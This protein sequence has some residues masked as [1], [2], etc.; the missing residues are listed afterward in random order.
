[1]ADDICSVAICERPS[2]SRGWC[3][4]HYM[5]WYTTGDVRA[6]EPLQPYGQ[7]G[8]KIEGCED[9]TKG[10]R[11]WCGKH[12][13][14]WRKNGDPHDPGRT[15]RSLAERLWEKVDVGHP[16]GCW[17]WTG[18]SHPL[19]YGVIRRGGREEGTVGAHRAAYEL[20]VGGCPDGFELDHLCCNPP[21]V[22]PDHL[23][24]VTHA[25][26]A[27]RGATGLYPRG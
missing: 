1:M 9:A 18:G 14:R 8:C 23:E 16:L 26:N 11:G 4:A 25:E 22:N 27:R 10:A 20:L 2:K 24:P 3:Q 13:A 15:E 21:C 12:Y 19:G 17:M 5:R 6:D 7:Q